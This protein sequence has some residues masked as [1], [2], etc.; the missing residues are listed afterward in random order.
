MPIDNVT[1]QTRK[2]CSIY[3][4]SA[5]PSYTNRQT[6]S[7]RLHNN[8]PLTLTTKVL[9]FRTSA[10]LRA[11]PPRSLTPL[12]YPF[13]AMQAVV[14]RRVFDTFEHAGKTL[15]AFAFFLFLSLGY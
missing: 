10:F 15:M 14:V 9:F 4:F 11:V 7:R 13:G 2:I 3:Q 8:L 1:G 6:P 5:M 12:S